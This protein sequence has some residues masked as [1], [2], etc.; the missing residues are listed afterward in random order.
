MTEENPWVTHSTEVGYENPW[1]RV[2]HSE[3]TTPTGTPG[4]YGVVRFKNL[5]VGVVPIDDEDH[6][7]LVGQYRYTLDE[8]SWEIPEGGCPQGEDPAETARRELLEETGL[9]AE[10]I[11]PLLSGIRLSNSVSDET[12]YA[13]VATGLTAGAAEPDETEDLQV[14]RVPVDEVIE[15]VTDGRINDSL[16]VLAVQRLALLRQS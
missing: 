4:I 15:M 5:A 10:T 11:E 1:I 12:A 8:Y 7:W 13:F 9:R 14:R 16:T 3:V 2:D 6:T